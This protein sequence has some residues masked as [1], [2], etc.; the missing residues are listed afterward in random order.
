MKLGAFQSFHGDV[1][2][3]P[4]APLHIVLCLIRP[5]CPASIQYYDEKMAHHTF[6]GNLIGFYLFNSIFDVI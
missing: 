1:F 3:T 6:H 4:P 5:R 2:L